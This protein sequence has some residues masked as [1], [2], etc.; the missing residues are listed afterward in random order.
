MNGLQAVPGERRRRSARDHNEM[1]SAIRAW[2]NRLNDGGARVGRSRLRPGETWAYN[3]D[4]SDIE[5]FEVAAITGVLYDDSDNAAEVQHRA[6]LTISPPIEASAGADGFA[7]AAE[8]IAAGAIGRVAITG[9][10]YALLDVSDADHQYAQTEDG[11]SRL[12]SCERGGARVLWK[13]A[14]TGTELAAIVQLPGVA[15]TEGLTELDV[16]AGD[17][18]PIVADAL[19]TT[20]DAA[21]RLTNVAGTIRVALNLDTIY[22]V[23]NAGNRAA[24]LSEVLALLSDNHLA[25]CV[26]AR[27]TNATA[28]HTG[29]LGDVVTVAGGN[30]L[31][32]R[33]DATI[34]DG[35]NAA[36][37]AVAYHSN[38]TRWYAD[39][40]FALE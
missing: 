28:G 32:V 23:N 7:V 16:T 17:G 36:N 26:A 30:A 24:P 21:L 29:T 25:L 12:Q 8:R 38:T 15:G 22:V 37:L 18:T 31:K 40:A 13:A 6:T 1:L 35:T 20:L 9:A 33:H 2:R 3:T 39:G 27:V 5:A 10:A 19:E 34:S 14:G 11:E 4:A